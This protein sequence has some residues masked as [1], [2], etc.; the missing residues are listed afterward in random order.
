MN[1]DLQVPD[2]LAE[3]SESTTG[4]SVSF[5]QVVEEWTYLD[6]QDQWDA[7]WS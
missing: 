6:D 2:D 1:F 5:G 7:F 4:L 3:E